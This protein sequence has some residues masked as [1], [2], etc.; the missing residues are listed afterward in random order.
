MRPSPAAAPRQRSASSC[1]ASAPH[2]ASSTSYPPRAVWRKRNSRS[3]PSPARGASSAP[4]RHS[5][6]RQA[7]GLENGSIFSMRSAMASRSPG[8]L[9]RKRCTIA[10]SSRARD[11]RMS[12]VSAAFTLMRLWKRSCS[13]SLSRPLAR[14][15]TPTLL[16]SCRTG[17]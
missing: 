8:A 5:A 1:V 11:W 13:S 16:A 17:W 12:S 6:S 4:G 14:R 9:A 7:Q 15:S 3:A 10:S 2:T